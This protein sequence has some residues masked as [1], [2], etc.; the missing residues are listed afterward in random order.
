MK[1]QSVVFVWENFGPAHLDRCEAAALLLPHPWVVKGIELANKSVSYDWV[2]SKEN[3]F[4]KTT[5]FLGRSIAEV[6]FL[7]RTW[8][9]L[10]ACWS[11]RPAAYFFCHYEQPATFVCALILRICGHKV[12]VMNDSK[13]DDYPRYFFRELIKRFFYSPYQGA[14]ASGPRARDYLRYLGIADSKIQLNYDVLSIER[15]RRLGQSAP[16]PDGLG[17]K[18]RHFTIIARFLPKKNIVMALQAYSLYRK[19]VP[20]P[21]SLHLCGSGQLE[22]DLRR[23]VSELD[24]EESVIFHGFVQSD[25]ICRI[26]ANTLALL[27]PS[28]EEQFGHVVI[29]AQ[30]MGVPVIVSNN[31]GA[32][33]LLVRNGVNGFVIEP[34]NPQGTAFFMSLLCSDENLWRKMSLATRSFVAK[35]DVRLFVEAVAALL[36][37]NLP[38]SNASGHEQS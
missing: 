13:F 2:S 6:P 8:A 16:A 15:I 18:E 24:L 7:P 22:A 14:L 33:D 30:A 19:C 5:L 38:I 28:L 35:G 21:R 9:T 3:T 32:C 17:H 37:A 11:A 12:F 10:R 23:K 29:E 20:T 34:D 1:E 26:L 27:L 4:E 36:G 25:G 31:C